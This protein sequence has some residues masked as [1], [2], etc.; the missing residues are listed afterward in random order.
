MSTTRRLVVAFALNAAL[1]IAEVF[2]AMIAHSAALIADAGH[3][4]ADVA[5]LLLALLA[6]RYSL[7]R[8]TSSRSFGYHR[9][10]I[11]AALANMVILLVVTIGV[12][13]EAIWKLQHVST[14]R[15]GVVVVVALVATAIDA[16]SALVLLDRSRDLNLKAAMVHLGADAI[17][18]LGITI[19][20][21][22][23][24]ST[25]RLFILDPIVSLALA[26]LI[27]I[28]A[29]RIGRA[30]VNV[31]LESV[32]ADVDPV[33]VASVIRAVDGVDGVHHLHC[34]SLSGDVRAL[35]AHVLI[36]GH[37]TLEEAQLVGERVKQ[38]IA[39][40]FSISHSTLELECEPCLDEVDEFCEI[41]LP[42]PGA[43]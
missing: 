41:E 40:R 12:A 25:G 6:H 29:V 13:A 21:I 23:E 36:A 35:S 8:P 11:L 38:A 28:E 27:A 14:L 34:W 24:Y 33:E 30:S 32:P 17:S 42:I 37:P 9:A 18:S 31:L 22:V 26:V 7:R 4:T 16:I 39:P 43:K 1:V 15:P 19:A 5:A 3:N 2:G 20:A 10:T